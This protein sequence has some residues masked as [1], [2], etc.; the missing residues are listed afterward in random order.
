MIDTFLDAFRTERQEQKDLITCTK[1]AAKAAVLLLAKQA[2][3]ALTPLLLAV[4]FVAAVVGIIVAAILAAIYN[5]PIAIFFP[6]PD[7]KSVV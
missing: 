1:S 3:A 5:S 6:L 4:S 2:A 7:R